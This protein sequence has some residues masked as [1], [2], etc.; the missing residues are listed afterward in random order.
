[1]IKFGG[2]DPR[3]GGTQ[4]SGARQRMRKP[5]TLL[6]QEQAQEICRRLTCGEKPT[7]LAR[8]FGVVHGVVYSIQKGEWRPWHERRRLLTEED[9]RQIRERRTDGETLESLA[10]S[11]GVTHGTISSLARGKTYQ[12]VEAPLS[13]L[14]KPGR[15]RRFSDEQIADMRRRRAAGQKLGAIAADYGVSDDFVNQVV[16]L[17]MYRV[18]S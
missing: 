13:L 15:K 3:F 14:T 12:E 7:D 10:Q 2:V 4:P 9:A 6:T 17:R 1:M 5:K 8:E 18:A 11:Y 16:L